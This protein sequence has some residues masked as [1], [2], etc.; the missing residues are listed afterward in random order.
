[1]TRS[2]FI[3]PC[4]FSG[5]YDYDVFPALADFGV[6]SYDWATAKEVWAR[7]KPMTCQGTMVAQALQT[8]QLE[9]SARL[10]LDRV[11][12]VCV[13]LRVSFEL[14]FAPVLHTLHVSN[15]CFA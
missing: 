5:Y 13:L 15:N 12:C 11:R 2:T 6:V 8:K 14:L 1:M 7:A 9:L 4:N 3:N 10:K